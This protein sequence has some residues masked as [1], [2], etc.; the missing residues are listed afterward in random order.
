MDLYTQEAAR[1]AYEGDG[2]FL[3]PQAVIPPATAAAALIGMD[4]VR[5]GR[6]D[7]GTEPQPSPWK[8]GD[9]PGKLCKIEM[10]QLANRAIWDLV[11]HPALGAW[12]GAL[13]GA[14]WVQVWW[15]QLLYKPA[16][17]SVQS[18]PSTNVGWHQ[19]R[20]YW[21]AWEEGSELFTAWV[22]LEEVRP[23]SGPMRFVR[24]SHRWGFLEQSDFFGQ[25]LDGQRRALPVPAGET[26]AETEVNLPAG[27]ASFHHC[28]TLHASGPNHSQRPR[29]SFA[30]HL[31][32][33]SSRPVEDRRAGLT[34]FIDEPQHCPVIFRRKP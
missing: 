22:A 15:V 18:S 19:D 25:D 11:S 21:R 17:P 30:I 13:T 26:W 34:R 5:A 2:Y 16:L 32:T 23:E 4:E 6:Y 28:L 31:R 14:E 10:P 33:N 12:A 9:D 3:C 1:R 24:G 27:G 29:R 8:P 20:Y 7:T